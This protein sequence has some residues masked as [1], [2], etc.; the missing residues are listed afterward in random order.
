[1]GNHLTFYL[2]LEKQYLNKFEGN[3]QVMILKDRL[4]IINDSQ[5]T[6]SV[7]KVLV[8]DSRMVN[9]MDTAGK[10]SSKNLKRCEDLLKSCT[11]K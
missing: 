3:S 6:T 10:D 9:I 4:I 5:L 7:D 1:M 11:A 8:G 2:L